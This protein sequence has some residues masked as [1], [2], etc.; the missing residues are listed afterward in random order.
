MKNLIGCVFGRYTVV[1]LDT[2]RDKFG[3]LKWICHCICGEVRSVR[4]DQLIS[5]ESKSCG[6][7]GAELRKTH[8]MSNSAEYLAWRNAKSRCTNPKDGNYHQYGGRGIEMCDRWLNS[9]ANFYDDMGPK[10]SPEHSLDR[11][12]VDG[13]YDP[14]N[15]RWA[16]KEEQ[17]N[18][19]QDS[20]HYELEGQKLTVPQLARMFNINKHTLKD[21]LE[22]GMAVKDAISQDVAT[23]AHLYTLNGIT[24]GIVQWAQQCNVP[25]HTLY[26]R[27]IVR[28]WSIEKALTEPFKIINRTK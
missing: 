11:E 16:T 20:V 25:Y 21:R 19:K 2:V 7:L 1:E 6:C 28:K 27:L 3:R 10:P 24:Q 5:G 13:D 9:F 26:R 17:D 15:C 8:G 18:N 12:E 14:D 22:K 23:S 4:P